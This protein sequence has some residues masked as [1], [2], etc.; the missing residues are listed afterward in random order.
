MDTSTFANTLAGGTFSLQTNGNALLLVFTAKSS[1]VIGDIIQ[2]AGSLIFSGTG[3]SAGGVCY[4]LSST[5]LNTPTSIWTRLAT[6]Y[7]DVNGRFYFTNP[8]SAGTPQRFYQLEI[9]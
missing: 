9:P 7:F 2:N 5:N 4:V 8:I 1:P 6:N 3:V